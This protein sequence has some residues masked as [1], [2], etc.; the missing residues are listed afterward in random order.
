MIRTFLDSAVLIAAA[1]GDETRSESALK[2]L[3][4][5]NRQILTSVFV[6]LEV[7]PKAAFN[8]FPLQRAF[9]NEF[10]MD[11]A[12]EWAKDLQAVVQMALSEAEKYG[13]AAM[14]ALHVGAAEIL[15]ADQLITLERPGKPLYRVKHVEVVYIGGEPASKSAT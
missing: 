15:R 14:D 6:R 7:Y 10:F 8:V 2:V 9:L 4:D 3:E 5:P 1:R 11:P 13:L 12:I